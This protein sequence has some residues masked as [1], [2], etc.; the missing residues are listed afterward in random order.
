MAL[1]PLVVSWLRGPQLLVQFRAA[2]AFFGFL[3]PKAQGLINPKPRFALGPCRVQVRYTLRCL[4]EFLGVSTAFKKVHV[5]VQVL[6]FRVRGVGS[7]SAARKPEW[8]R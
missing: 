2:P 8:D 3:K 1:K 6:E 4:P 7:D 5:W